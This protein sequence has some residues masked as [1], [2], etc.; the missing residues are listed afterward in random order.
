MSS[1]LRLSIIT[2]MLLATVMLALTAYSM[3][4]PAPIAVQAAP[5]PQAP[6]TPTYLVTKYPL[7]EGTL[8]R[9]QYLRSVS[10]AET[11]SGAF[12]ADDLPKL[13]GSLVRKSVDAGSVITS[14]SV[15][16]REDP[17]FFPVLEKLCQDANK[18]QSTTVTIYRDG[19]ADGYSVRKTDGKADAACIELDRTYPANKVVAR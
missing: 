10:L 18:L 15:M 4:H 8:L 12:G 5:A 19:K 2:V 17:G 6:P 11:P 16:L 3:M 7:T 1:T 13:R 9:D 14:Q